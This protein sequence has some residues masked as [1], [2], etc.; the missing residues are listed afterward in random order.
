MGE[1]GDSRRDLRIDPVGPE[2]LAHFRQFSMF[3]NPGA[4]KDKLVADL[5]DDVAEI[6]KLVRRQIIHRVTLANGNTG[7]NADLR[8]G[9]MNRVP[10]WRQP[11]DDV[12]STAAGMI[13]ELY[14]RDNRGFVHDRADESKLIL[15]CRFVAVLMASILKS[16]GKPARVRSGFEAYAPP[17]PGVSC[18]HW[19][20]QYWEESNDR[21]ITIDV[22]CCLEEMDF[23]PFDMPEDE[24]DWSADAWRA[25]RSGKAEPG[26]FWN[27]G[28][29]EG[30]MPVSWELYHDFHC[31]MGNEKIYL[32]NPR[33]VSI[34]NFEKLSEAQLRQIDK[35][36]VL[37]QHPD[38]NFSVLCQLW[39]SDRQ[40]RL[41]AG[42]LL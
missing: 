39:E 9:D 32:H 42:A 35:L 26:R 1:H 18:D 19:I 37:M 11:E 34:G 13:A 40:G 38:E 23:D 12:L 29:F 8:Y 25:L 27:A 3:T 21:W 36:A 17:K 28:G 6:G 30:L 22:D 10:W 31:L 41:L 24:F 33:H 2:M 14:R 16:K 4:Y 15:T 20:T 5:P 7:S